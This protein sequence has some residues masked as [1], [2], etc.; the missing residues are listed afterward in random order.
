MPSL[1]INWP[2]WQLVFQSSNDAVVAFSYVFGVA[3]II[4][5]GIK[6]KKLSDVNPDD[7]SLSRIAWILVAGIFCLYFA[8][9]NKNVAETIFASDINAFDSAE[10]ALLNSASPVAPL[11][12]VFSWFSVYG[13]YM[14]LR[15]YFL[16]REIGNPRQ[17]SNSPGSKAI[18]HVIGGS[19]LYYSPSVASLFED[20]IGF[21]YM[22]FLGLS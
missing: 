4:L 18:W 6:V 19:F 11:A 15:G 7:T 17:Q 21:N 14:M 22:E 16:F 13:L 3:L 2:S 8:E 9:T 20:N 10:Y 1:N 5:T 12:F